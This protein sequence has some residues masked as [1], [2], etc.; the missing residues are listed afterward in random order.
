M[1]NIFSIIAT[2]VCL[3]TYAQICF[4][5]VNYPVL[6]GGTSIACN[7]FNSDG[8]L[9]LIVGYSGQPIYLL[10]GDG[11]GGFGTGSIVYEDSSI[12]PPILWTCFI[13]GDY[14]KDGKADLAIGEIVLDTINDSVKILFG[15]G[16]GNFLSSSS[17]V[18]GYYPKAIC[19]S[20][21]NGDGNIDLATANDS[22]V[23]VL[24]GDGTGNFFSHEYFFAGY[25]Q[26][27][28][29]SGDFNGD[30]KADL[31]I[32][33]NGNDTDSVCVLIG[34]GAGSFVNSTK[35]MTGS[36]PHSVCS[37]DFNKDGYDDLAVVNSNSGNVSVFISKGV[38]GLFFNA[39]NNIAGDGTPFSAPYSVVSE[40]FNFDG[41][42]DLAVANRTEHS[43]YILLGTGTATFGA[44]TY[45]PALYGPWSIICKDFNSDGKP[46]LATANHSS[47]DVTVLLNCA[48]QGIIDINNKQ[49]VYI[50]PN[51]TTGKFSIE[52]ALTGKLSV[53][54]FNL[55]GTLV[56]SQIINSRINIDATGLNEG[57]YNLTIK[58]YA[59]VINKKL[60]IIK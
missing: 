50:Y 26:N 56:F 32:T 5:S 21:F 46:D 59:S 47:D 30:S 29:T 3:N 45:Y 37:K 27:S 57:F 10:L 4:T 11:L 43:V 6:N 14:N 8:K 44:F 19:S 16:T 58:S 52:T 41:Y 33:C 13:S 36:G 2:T 34:D 25:G 18:I 31:A 12:S 23:S 28:I 39:I 17:F 35:Y 40:D 38:S 54:I 42:L 20:D 15:D 53:Q 1:K 24:L 51:P 22:S 7:D 49:D 9:D 48:T 55:N 60:V